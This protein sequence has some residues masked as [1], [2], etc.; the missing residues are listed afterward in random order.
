MRQIELAKEPDF[1]LG[2]VAVAPALRQLTT[3]DGRS[4]VIEHRV[5]QVLIALQAADG[6]IVTRDELTQSCWDGRIVGD[7]AINRVI[8]RLRRT[9]QDL[10]G[11][12]FR[13]ETISKVGYRLV[14]PTGTPANDVAEQVTAPTSAAETASPLTPDAAVPLDVVP[15]PT[16]PGGAHPDGRERPAI[17]RRFAAIISTILLLGMGAYWT[18]LRHDWATGHS[19]SVRLSGYQL[20]SADL[21]AAI[22]VSTNAEVIAAFNVDGMIGISDTSAVTGAR[23]PPYSLGGTIYRTGK[24]IRVISRLIND[25]SGVVLWSD[26]TDYPGDQISQVPHK[27]AITAG[28]VVRCGLSGAANH[29]KALPD[30][31]MTNYL[32]YCQ[33]YWSYGG[34]KTLHFAQRVVAEVPDFSWGWSAVGNGYVQMLGGAGG[35]SE[36]VLRRAGIEAED[37]ALMLDPENGEALAHKAYLIDQRDWAGQEALFKAAIAAKPLDCGCEHYGYGLKLQSVGRLQA[38]IDEFRAATNMLALW[39]DSQLAL[40]SAL[41]ATGDKNEARQSFKTATDLSVDPVVAAMIAINEGVETGDYTAALAALG[42]PD[43]PLSQSS[44]MA[45]VTS[46]KALASRKPQLHG[47]A[48]EALVKLPQEEKS[49]TVVRM[50]S[51]LGAHKAALRAVG[52]RPWLFWRRSMRGVLDEPTF[53][54]VARKLGLMTYWRS[55]HTR[56]DVCGDEAPAFCRMI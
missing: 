34:S 24:S 9:A 41:V 22:R 6:G 14:L 32:R 30:T 40:A 17:G 4:L 19:M 25:R 31:A 8:S 42:K 43:L 18:W 23:Q 53:P 50:L 3:G 29:R 15:P 28:I 27:V 44:R 10:G 55:S 7:D 47:E 26:A 1:L 56:P 37:K 11:E 48:V 54:A 2:R 35:Q 36:A 33:E 51:A 21:P 52:E 38:A 39:P 5:M 20:P 16:R 45:L 13:V 12:V 46:Y 49:G